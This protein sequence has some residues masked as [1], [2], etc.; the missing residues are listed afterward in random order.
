MA[1][2]AFTIEQIK[3]DFDLEIRE[4]FGFYER[5][6]SVKVRKSL[7][8]GVSATCIQGAIAARSTAVPIRRPCR[9]GTRV[10]AREGRRRAQSV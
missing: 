1:Y 6:K 7:Q 3:E 4:D 8:A 10:V 2:S 9:I 5:T